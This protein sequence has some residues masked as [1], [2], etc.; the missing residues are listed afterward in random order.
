MVDFWVSHSVLVCILFFV[1]YIVRLVIVNGQ[2]G[3][4]TVNGFCCNAISKVGSVEVIGGGKCQIIVSV[5]VKE[6]ITCCTTPVF[7]Q[8]RQ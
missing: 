7:F 4:M 6:L 1:C 5:I 8:F 2:V 3:I